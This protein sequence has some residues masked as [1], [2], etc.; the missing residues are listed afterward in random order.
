MRCDV[1]FAEVSD[2]A[3]DGIRITA[4]DRPFYFTA[5]HYTSDQLSK[6]AH[7]EDVTQ[8]DATVLSI[9][10]YMLGTGSNSCGPMT[11]DAYQFVPKKRQEISFRFHISPIE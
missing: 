5:A 1:R 9:D 3:G 11:L 6:W 8:Y 10:G 4:V 2:A 7:R